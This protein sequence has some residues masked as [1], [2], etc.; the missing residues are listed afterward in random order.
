MLLATDSSL[1][2]SIDDAKK[3]YSSLFVLPSFRTLL[4]G[5]ALV[6][7]VAGL[8]SYLFF[9]SAKGLFIGFLLGLS[10]FLL[11]FLSDTL[12]SKKIL[13]D[14]VFTLRRTTAL[15]F[16]GWIFWLAF[17]IIGTALSVLFG[18]LVWIRLCLLGFSVLVTLRSVVF[19]SVASGSNQRILLA[20]LLQP[21]LCIL[22]FV[23][24]WQ[25]LNIAAV[26]YL[27]FL[28]VSPFV[29][30]ISAKVF[31]YVLDQMGKTSYGV[32]SIKIFKSFMLNWVAALNSPLESF[33]EEMG[34]DKDVPVN[35]L[36]FDSSK[37]K[38]AIIVPFVHPGPFKNIGSSLL[39]SLL[40][41]E[42]EKTYNCSACVPLGLLG[43]ELDAA[44]QAQN[45]KIIDHVLRGADFEASMSK[46]TPFVR[47]SK[48]NVSAS[49]QI[50]EKTALLSFTLSPKTTEDFPQE[51]ERIIQEETKM[52]G[53]DSA[54]LINAHNSLTENSEN[55]ASLEVLRDVAFDCLQKAISQKS[56]LFEVGS[57]TVYPSEFSLKDGMGAG[58]ITAVVIRVNGEKALYV[59][60]DGNNM[61]SGLREKILCALNSDGFDQCEVF[62]TDTHAVSAVVVGRRGYHPIGE[63]INQDRLIEI[64]KEAAHNAVANLE[65]CKVGYRHIEVPKVRLIGTESLESLTVLIDK[66]IRRAKQIVAPIFG[67]EGL[68]LI[69]L[70]F[71]I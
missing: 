1:N 3:H 59:V 41:K 2:R 50:F 8:T 56:Y 26:E 65:T 52:L 14:L 16:V 44:S 35:L 40:K 13:D 57:A 9:S 48:G 54:I 60:I 67:L 62:T 61:I 34:K 23:T 29:A 12:I 20:I 10:F 68:L 7:V 24:L 28:V 22:P 36:K 64:I 42:F 37:P 32:A 4:I 69:L 63:L 21:I 55:E 18:S 51:L 5:L 11:N 49:C 33:F 53:L 38:A 17:L 71:L 25:N 31:I 70:L 46:A 39:P 66:T 58:G 6:N 19:F 47:V 15:S 27:P 30:I 45:H 43:H